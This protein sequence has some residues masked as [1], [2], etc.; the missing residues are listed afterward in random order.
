MRDAR[1]APAT[2]TLDCGHTSE[3]PGATCLVCFP[4]DPGDGVPEY[5]P[6]LRFTGTGWL[7][8]STN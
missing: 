5:A 4:P 2:C 7:P 1:Q 8:D 3:Y 6:G